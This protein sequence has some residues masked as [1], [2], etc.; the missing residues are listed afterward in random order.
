MED[1]KSLDL[2]SHPD[3]VD[4]HRDVEEVARH[5]LRQLKYKDDQFDKDF[6]PVVERQVNDDIAEQQ[7]GILQPVSADFWVDRK[8]ETIWAFAARMM[9]NKHNDPGRKP[10][11]KGKALS[12]LPILG[13]EV[14]PEYDEYLWRKA[15]KQR[16]DEEQRR[17]QQREEEQRRQQQAEEQRR[18]AE[19]RQAEVQRQQQ[20]QKQAARK[21]IPLRPRGQGGARGH[22]RGGAPGPARQ[23][24][25]RHEQDEKRSRFATHVTDPDGELLKTQKANLEALNEEARNPTDNGPRYE[26]WAAKHTDKSRQAPDPSIFIPVT[27]DD[28]N[29]RVVTE[30]PYSVLSKD[31]IYGDNPPT[32][33][34]AMIVPIPHTEAVKTVCDKQDA[35][36]EQKMKEA[37]KQTEKNITP[38]DEKLNY[39]K[40][41]AVLQH[42]L[43]R[44]EGNV[45]DHVWKNVITR[46]I[47]VKEGCEPFEFNLPAQKDM[48]I[49][50]ATNWRRAQ[51]ECFET[52]S[53]GVR[54]YVKYAG[55]KIYVG[56]QSYADKIQPWIELALFQMYVVFRDWAS[57]VENGSS[58]TLNHCLSK[59]H[60]RQMDF[61]T[62]EE[63][64]QDCYPITEINETTQSQ[65][66]GSKKRERSSS[67]DMT[68]K[69][70]RR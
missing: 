49:F 52:M 25:E 27:V 66:K 14:S 42:D 11:R 55:D 17:Q 24:A 36:H 1:K 22:G 51:M 38:A 5:M 30:N 7:K 59:W 44:A 69:K 34:P 28:K 35:S 54:M 21:D 13:L 58:M 40:T 47:K 33:P 37:S 65:A 26:D 16:Q 61:V 8:I 29:N 57:G 15:V 53:F 60:A 50:G 19:Q 45:M 23:S 2:V 41:Y 6:I 56:L 32:P 10:A 46:R 9:T 31:N 67:G 39:H 20:Q 63:A 18:Q 43:S 4:D 68:S 70:P 48:Y 64:G 62:G 12:M 3:L